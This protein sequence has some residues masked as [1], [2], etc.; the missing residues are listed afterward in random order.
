MG[1]MSSS[2]REES[3]MSAPHRG[4]WLALGAAFCA[5][6][7]MCSAAGGIT[8]DEK[9]LFSDGQWHRNQRKSIPL[10]TSCYYTTQSA[11]PHGCQYRAAQAST[12][13][14]DSQRVME[15]QAL[16]DL[17]YALNGE[18]WRTLD[19]WHED[20]DPCWDFWYGVT[21]DEHGY[22]IKLELADNRLE[23]FLPVSLGNLISLLKID[24]SSTQPD[25]HQHENLN[26]NRI[27]GRMPSLARMTRLEEIEV[28]GNLITQLP[29]DLYTN[30]KTL[31]SLCASNNKLRKL[32]DNLEEFKVLH[33]LELD[34]N[35][36]ADDFPEA[37]GSLSNARIVHL[38]YNKLKGQINE[39]II[40]MNR[41]R[42]FD[43]A[44]NPALGGQLPEQ[45]IVQWAETDY[46]SILN[47]SISGYISSLCLDVPFCWKFMYDTHKDLTWATV[48]DVPDIV[49]MT[50]DLAKSGR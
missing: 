5:L 35:M 31:R 43:V 48:Q 10:E 16:L 20:L 38:Q 12:Y 46:L 17:F 27:E 15:K 21:C 36:I 32:P 24:L 45:I 33:T 28:S 37:F 47:T 30:A 9:L 18:E 4:W 19:N 13:K 39:A 1:L 2:S 42:V 40:G 29:Q 49:T 3:S 41:V 11:L 25:Y 8:D 34:N 50:I 26:V 23:G 22:V 7:H 14:S 44:H 6:F